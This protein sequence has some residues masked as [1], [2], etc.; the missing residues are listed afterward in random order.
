MTPNNQII[1]DYFENIQNEGS[2]QNTSQNSINQTTDQ[3]S[4]SFERSNKSFNSNE[5]E[6]GA[7]SFDEDFM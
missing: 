6:K 2:W 1:L 3:G 4:P 5:E 7:N